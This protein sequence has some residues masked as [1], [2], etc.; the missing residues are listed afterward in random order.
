MSLLPVIYICSTMFTTLCSNY[1]QSYT[2][3]HPLSIFISI[4]NTINNTPEVIKSSEVK[5]YLYSTLK[6]PQLN[7]VLNRLKLP[8]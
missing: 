7:K 5:V 4:I 6:Q 3:H 8:R 2:P 1:A